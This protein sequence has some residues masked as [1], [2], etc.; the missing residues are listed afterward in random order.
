[1]SNRFLHVSGDATLFISMKVYIYILLEPDNITVRYVGK[2]NEYRIGK[3]LGEHCRYSQLKNHT[4]KNTWVKSLLS[5]GQHPI[6]RIIEECQEDTYREREKYWVNFYKKS[7]V[8]LVN[9][10]EGGEGACRIHNRVITDSQKKTISETLKK[11]HKEH[12]EMYENCS[13]AGKLTRGIKRS[14]SFTQT[15]SHVGISQFKTKKGLLWKWRAYV[16]E[17]G[18]QNHLGL[19]PTEQ[20]AIDY[21]QSYLN[22]TASKSTK[23]TATL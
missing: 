21:R 8:G 5:K 9:G 20:E 12:P 14:F 7:G 18:K 13:K 23:L 1:M 16:W 3:R 10:T 22:E 4:H 11:R 2:S 6:L 19:F 15:S 17:N